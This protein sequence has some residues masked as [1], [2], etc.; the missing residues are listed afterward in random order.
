MTLQKFNKLSLTNSFTNP[1]YVEIRNAYY[2]LICKN[3]DLI[4]DLQNSTNASTN[5]NP[6]KWDCSIIA[7]VP[8]T[9]TAAHLLLIMIQKRH[10]INNLNFA[11]IHAIY[12][13]STNV[14]NLP[15]ANRELHYSNNIK[16]EHYLGY[17]H[18]SV[19]FRK[20]REIE[21]IQ[22]NKQFASE[23]NQV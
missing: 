7:E 4:F 6:T 1:R 13:Q 16:E 18:T 11:F 17:G 8:K 23:V 20:M 3:T 21:T 9:V 14:T 10:V 5:S 2:N 19:E 12:T 15:T 22:Q